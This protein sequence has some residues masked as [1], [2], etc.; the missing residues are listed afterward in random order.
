MYQPDGQFTN[1][2][3][4]AQLVLTNDGKTEAASRS[5]YYTKDAEKMEVLSAQVIKK[6]GTVVPV[7][8]KDIQDTEQSG[9]VNIYD[10]QGRAVKVTFAEPR[11]R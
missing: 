6:D 1:T 2:L 10:P 9:E 7:D 3:H 8:K 4:S 11:G 5:L